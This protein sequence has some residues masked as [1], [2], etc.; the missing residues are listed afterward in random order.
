MSDC[1][2]IVLGA[3]SAGCVVANRLSEN[4][5]NRVLL[6]EAGGRDWSPL[7]H[8][9][10]ASGELLRKGSFGWN[11]FTDAI[12]DLG[13]RTLFWP[14]G[15]VLG[16]SSSINGQVYIRGHPSD[17]DHWAALGNR[18][19]SYDDVLPYFLKSEHHV[20]RH[21]AFHGKDGEWRISRGGMKN[22]LFDAFVEAGR[23]AG[24]AVNDDFNGSRQE[25][26]GRFDF[27]VDRGR[28]Q[29]SA[30]AFLAKAKRRPNLRIVSH[31]QVLRLI[32]N[33]RRATGVEA[34]HKGTTVRFHAAAQIVLCCGVIG[35]PHLLLLSGI[36]DGE[37][38]SRFGIDVVEHSAG[39]GKNLQDHGQVALL[40]GCKQPVTLYQLIRIDRAVRYMAQAILARSG[41]FTHFPVQGA[42]FTRSRPG[43]PVPDTQWHFGIG[44]GV[45]RAR[46]P[47][48]T[49]SQ[50][51]LDRDGYLIAPCLLRPE[52]R[53]EISLRSAEP[54]ENPSIQP[55]YLAAENDIQF[56]REAV[57]EARRI[58]TQPAFSPFR[59]S[60]ISPGEEVE[61][62]GEID[63]FVSAN[64]S[65]CH[66]QVGTCKMGLDALSVVDDQLR[67][68]GVDGLRVADAS[69][70][71]TLLGGNTNA[72]AVM[73]GEKAADMILAAKQNS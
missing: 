55:N 49:R 63:D 68:R 33:K 58:A 62:D 47:R 23:Q 3:G 39:V 13:G 4:P 64:F 67:V 73:I 37:Q 28:R 45:R 8:V 30:K 54:L 22:P 6:I 7:I 41:P 19:W 61:T 18:G 72:A 53:G 9:P 52:S 25:G 56:F 57:R 35:S 38:L 20:D 32:W 21:D 71:P 29:S 51:P 31:A 44:L 34:V 46:W 66:H 14:R 10:M 12:P 15:K 70:M 27:M 69:I 60:E 24:Y 17:Y 59:D 2:Y 48:L 11:Y 43:L 42:A 16:G 50:D 26:F 1:D 36:G 65:T 40:Y 5:R